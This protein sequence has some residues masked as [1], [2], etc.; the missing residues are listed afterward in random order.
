MFK[1]SVEAGVSAELLDVLYP[2]ICNKYPAMVH[3]YTQRINP[4]IPNEDHE[5][6]IKAIEFL[7]PQSKKW[8]MKTG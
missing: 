5:K 3:E 6:M 2:K 1:H 8:S 4:D 7:C